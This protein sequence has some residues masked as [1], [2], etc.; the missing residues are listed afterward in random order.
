LTP[1]K[2]QANEESTAFKSQLIN[3]SNGKLLNSLDKYEDPQIELRKASLI[4]VEE[5]KHESEQD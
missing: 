1:C 4:Q 3:S 2:F 5:E